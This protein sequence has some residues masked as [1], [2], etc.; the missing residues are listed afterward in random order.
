MT[1]GFPNPYSHDLD[2]PRTPDSGYPGSALASVHQVAEIL[3][4]LTRIVLEQP[5]YDLGIV[6]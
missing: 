1:V 2:C 5:S 4:K 3:P 6:V